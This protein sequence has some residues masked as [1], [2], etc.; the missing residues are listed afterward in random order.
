MPTGSTAYDVSAGEPIVQAS[1]DALLLTPAAPHTRTHRPIVI[2][3]ASTVR[4][5]PNMD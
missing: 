4:I 2:P 3:G 1:V 5:Q